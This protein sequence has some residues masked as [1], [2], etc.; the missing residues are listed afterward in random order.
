MSTSTFSGWLFEDEGGRTTNGFF[1]VLSHAVPAS[2]FRPDVHWLEIEEQVDGMMCGTLHAHIL[3]LAVSER[4]LHEVLAA[5]DWAGGENESG[6]RH[7]L[8][9]HNTSMAT[10]SDPTVLAYLAAISS[11][12]LVWTP[13]AAMDG[14]PYGRR[15]AQAVYPFDPTDENLRALGLQHRIEDLLGESVDDSR[16][17]L[18]L[19]TLNDD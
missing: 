14:E 16:H 7:D 9:W 15:L 5:T 12:G 3:P 8:S 17:A 13:P 10:P 11:V 1:A 6:W 19:L 18:V 4:R 2:A